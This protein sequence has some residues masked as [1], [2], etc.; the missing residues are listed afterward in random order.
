M[1]PDGDVGWAELRDTWTVAAA[2]PAPGAAT[3]RTL[4]RRQTWGWMAGALGELGV[5]AGILALVA[6]QTHGQP[7]FPVALA[8]T[9]VLVAVAVA[10]SYWNRRGLWRPE[11][12]TT[13]A[14][15]L[16]A[17]Q[18]AR[19]A[20]RAVRFGYQLLA[21]E[22]LFLVLWLPWRIFWSG[23][24]VSRGLEVLLPGYGVL[25]AFAVIFVLVLR[26]TGRR[27]RSRLAQADAFLASL[28]DEERR[29]D[30]DGPRRWR[31]G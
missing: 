9:V 10:F 22:C 18:R 2:T 23:A 19:S 1:R 25:A 29:E 4:A 21:A 8:T 28:S 6:R 24:S 3:M 15:A 14:F 16:L 30:G 17:R 26:W 27:A 13:Y 20:T 11:A 31:R 7:G 12:Q 5:A